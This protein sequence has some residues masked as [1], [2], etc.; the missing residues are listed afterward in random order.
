M[1]ISIFFVTLSLNMKHLIISAFRTLFVILIATLLSACEERGDTVRAPFVLDADIPNQFL[2]F[3]NKQAPIAEGQYQ[4]F[5][6]PNSSVA[7]SYSGTLTIAGNTEDLTGSWLDSV[8]VD[9]QTTAM[10]SH[11]VNFEQAGGLTLSASCTQ[12]CTAV[13][14][15]NNFE[16]QRIESIDGQL[17]LSL[18]DNQISSVA[19]AEAYYQAVDPDDKRTT[20]SDWKTQNGFDNGHDEHMIFR[21]SKDLGYGRDMY[22]RFNDDGSLRAIFVNNFVV[23]QGTGNPSNYGP[24]NIMAAVDQNHDF[25]GGSNAIEFSPIDESDPSSDS[26]L[27]FFTF[28]RPDENGQQTRLTS[29]SLD[30]RGIKHMP[31]MCQACHGANL[32][33]LN[34][35]GTFN[36][37]ALKSAKLNQLEVPSFEFMADGEYSL[38]SQQVPMRNFNQG[39]HGVL[40]AISSRDSTEAGYWD[41]SF[42]E[43]IAAGRYNGTDFNSDT[44]IETHVPTGWQQ[45]DY[46]PEGVETLYK[47]VVEPNCISCHSIRGYNAGNDED[48]DLMTINGQEVKTGVAINFSNYEKFIGYS[49]IIIEYV[50]KR[51]AMPLSL[52]NYEQFWHPD[53]IAPSLLASFLPGFDV[54]NSD[55]EIQQPGLPVSKPGRDRYA[56]SPVLLNGGGSYF[57]Q[58]YQW[59]ITSSP[60]NSIASLGSP[61]QAQTQLI[62]DTD[63]DYELQLSVSNSRAQNVKQSVIITI[64]SMLKTGSEVNFVDDIK[65]ILQTTAYGGFYCQSCHSATSNIEGIPVYYD[66]NNL[67]LYRDVKSRVDFLDPDN[68]ILIRKP[69]RLQHGGGIRIDLET[70]IG[71]TRY[72]LIIDW[73]INGAPCGVGATCN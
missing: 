60:L 73:I 53:N 22:A 32:L 29:A 19:Y 16:F 3:L 2:T 58:E 54:L 52:R 21:D 33:P 43:A 68:S 46:R 28:T 66:D 6:L 7:G 67:N 63:G 31:S 12:A 41:S 36:V 42:A 14:T 62:A 17:S 20:L 55:G 10:E 23:T 8:D 37:L 38:E 18:D 44:F 40:Q 45:T 27:K 4:L 39:V 26:I 71:K 15:K 47:Q 50:Y 72:S 69:T 1:N 56:A 57:A 11:S 30:G 48:L 5:I 34:T 9:W 35:D 65:P 64:D 13:I 51:G 59:S 70:E 25:L 49:D 24:L 61:D